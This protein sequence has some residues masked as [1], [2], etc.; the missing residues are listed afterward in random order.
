MSQP[1]L[2][3]EVI[4]LPDNFCGPPLDLL[5]EVHAFPSLKTPELDTILQV[6][7]HETGVEEQNHLPRPAGHSSFDAVWDTVGFLGWKSTST[8]MSF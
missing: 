3:G 6:G 5:S 1:F 2:I 4:Q 8:H 7:S